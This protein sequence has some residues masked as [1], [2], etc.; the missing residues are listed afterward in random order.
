MSDNDYIYKRDLP[1]YIDIYCYECKRLVAMSNTT[2]HDGRRYCGR[3]SG[4]VP[5]G[6]AVA[7]LLIDIPGITILDL[8]GDEL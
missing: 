5:R 7:Q 4:D 6:A 1:L 2:E 8:R 3:C